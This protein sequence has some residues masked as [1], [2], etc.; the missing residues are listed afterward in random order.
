M[1]TKIDK[2]IEKALVTENDELAKI[3]TEVKKFNAAVEALDAQKFKLTNVLVAHYHTLE[4]K[5][6]KRITNSAIRQDITYFVGK[7]KDAN[8][9]LI[10]RVK[11]LL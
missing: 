3:E 10:K 2:L 11:E 5:D 9:S 4:S 7:L 1:T 6:P 8:Q